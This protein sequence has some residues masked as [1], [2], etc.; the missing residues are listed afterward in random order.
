MKRKTQPDRREK[1]RFDIDLPLH[2]RASIDG[3]T[4]RWGIGTIQDMSSGGINFRCRRE[5]PVGA[6]LEIII[7]WP[8]DRSDRAPVCLHAS[9]LVLRSRGSKTALRLTSHHFQIEYRDSQPMGAT[10]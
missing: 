8:T 6:R 4:S 9:G 5:F 2:F 10:A 1:R 3:A 7:D